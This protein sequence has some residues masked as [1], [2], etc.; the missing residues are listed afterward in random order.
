MENFDLVTS[1]RDAAG[2]R[3]PGTEADGLD[4]RELLRR[5]AYEIE[6]LRGLVAQSQPSDNT[7]TD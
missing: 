1:L 4:W 7:G 6:R 3:N 5:A 2:R